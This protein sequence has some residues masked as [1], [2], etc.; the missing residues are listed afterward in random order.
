MNILTFDI[1]EWYIEKKYYG[2][3]KE[4]LYEYDKCLQSLL[5]ELASRQ[6]F[7]TFFCVGKM[8]IDFPHVV[9]KIKDYGHEIGC[10]SNNHIWL[11]KLSYIEIK[12][13]TYQAIDA[14]EQCIGEKVTSYRAPAFSIGE[15][16]K[17]V[18][19]ILAEFGITK[20][21][22]IFPSSRD[23]GGFKG[24][25][26]KKPIIIQS[27]GL[28]IHE[29]P[30]PTVNILGGNFAFSGGGYFRFFPLYFIKWNMKNADYM[31]TYFH[32]ADLISGSNKFLSRK[33]YEIYF[34]EKGSFIQ[35]FKRY[36]K[37][38]VGIGKCYPKLLDIIDSLDFVNLKS[39]DAMV[40]WDKS[41][42]VKL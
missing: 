8:A 12:E 36:I 27:K 11:N 6:L 16:N 5:D 1:E 37:A 33:E 29:F 21:A 2:F 19:E 40:Q 13:D 15:C 26:Y 20:D 41:H 42:V 4:K 35:R 18:F 9:R 22:S 38:N 31:M 39:A 14:L 10:H 23:F 24:F 30:I 25:L 7:A 3:R 28:F 17:Y 34:Q 32:M